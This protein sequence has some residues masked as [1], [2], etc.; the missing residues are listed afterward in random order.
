MDIT[1]CRHCDTEYDA[2][3]ALVGLTSSLLYLL[4]CTH[5]IF[6]TLKILRRAE[7]CSAGAS[8]P[9][10]NNSV[11]HFD[12]QLHHILPKFLQGIGEILVKYRVHFEFS[13]SLLRQ[14]S[15]VRV[16]SWCGRIPALLER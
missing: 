14:R 1:T 6:P 10:A 8:S 12:V 15:T 2:T 7:L 5:R 13:A 4:L 11:R 3:R 16:V 9:V